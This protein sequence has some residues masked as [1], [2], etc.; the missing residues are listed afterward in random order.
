VAIHLHRKNGWIGEGNPPLD[1]NPDIGSQLLDRPLDDDR[2][3]QFPG[4]LGGAGFLFR[5]LQECAGGPDDEFPVPAEPMGHRLGEG[6]AEE[7]VLCSPGKDLKREYGQGLAVPHC[8][9][10]RGLQPSGPGK[11][12]LQAFQVGVKLRRTATAECRAQ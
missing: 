12:A 6:N 1:L 7:V 8:R 3:I 11:I 5:L 4:D 9:S 10:G 2:R